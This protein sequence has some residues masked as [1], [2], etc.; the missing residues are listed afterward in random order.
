MWT[1]VLS[2]TSHVFC[3]VFPTIFSLIGLLAG[4]GMIAMPASMVTMHNLIHAWELPM[5]ITSAAILVLGWAA[6]L[7]SEKL[8]CHSTGCAH[9]ACAPQKSKAHLVLKIGTVLFIFNVFIYA[10][11]HKSTW[12]VTH[13][14][15]HDYHRVADDGGSR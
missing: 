15:P 14:V 6:T 12:F 3:C 1:V 7:Y 11:I 10:T 8:D 9:G 5:I 13:V 4:A 2:E